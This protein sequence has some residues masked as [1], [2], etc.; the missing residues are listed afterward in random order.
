MAAL[1]TEATDERSARPWSNECQAWTAR[2]P[3]AAV[4][5]ACSP[6][7]L[8]NGGVCGGVFNENDRNLLITEQPQTGPVGKQ[9]FPP[10]SPA[11]HLAGHRGKRVFRFPLD[12]Q[13]QTGS[14]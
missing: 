7:F 2:T 13:T 1:C 12:V 14:T 4:Q 10:P 6:S 9:L 8:E 11:A 3:A 5:E